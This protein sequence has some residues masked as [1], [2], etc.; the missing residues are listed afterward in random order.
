MGS[1]SKPVYFKECPETNAILKRVQILEKSLDRSFSEIVRDAL[2]TY[3]SIQ[4]P[5]GKNV[6]YKDRSVMV[7]G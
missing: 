7:R 6:D 2:K 3:V 1:F 5:A 4:K